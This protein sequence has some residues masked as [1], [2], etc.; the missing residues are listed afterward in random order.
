MKPSEKIKLALDQKL[1][2][3]RETPASFTFFVSLHDFVAF[4]ESTP[5]F[6][7]FFGAAK[8]GSRAAEL[9][10]KYF[11]MKQVYQGIEDIDLRT[12]DDLGHDRYVAIRELSSIRNKDFSENNTF[13]KRRELLRKVAAEVHKTLNGY[14]AE[15]SG[16]P[17]PTVTPASAAV[18][19]R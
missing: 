17:A 16:A 13:W 1:K 14:L 15:T 11:V 5:A 19:A 4:V 12:A 18:H 10:P 9:S 8:K 6:A 7:V 3:V 2:V